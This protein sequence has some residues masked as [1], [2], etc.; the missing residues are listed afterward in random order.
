MSLYLS[1]KLFESNNQR[2]K[3]HFDNYSSLFSSN[4][5][6]Q[7]NTGKFHLYPEIKETHS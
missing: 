6:Y 2:L 7:Y 5:Y 4:I 3:L 1:L